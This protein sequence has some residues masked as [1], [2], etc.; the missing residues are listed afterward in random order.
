MAR[1]LSTT[2]HR[3]LYVMEQNGKI[4]HDVREFEAALCR[5]PGVH[6]MHPLLTA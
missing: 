3:A 2:K 5:T 1:R 6:R 4:D